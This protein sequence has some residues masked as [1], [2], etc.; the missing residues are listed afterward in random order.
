VPAYLLPFIQSLPRTLRQRHPVC[1]RL[2]C[3]D[4]VGQLIVLQ[5]V[6][7]RCGTEAAIESRDRWYN[8]LG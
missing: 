4:D 1:M 6:I 2:V 5:E 7:D 8:A 3:P